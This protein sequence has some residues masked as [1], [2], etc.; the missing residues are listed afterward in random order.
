MD[1]L[2]FA[3][4]VLTIQDAMIIASIAT[5]LVFG[6]AAASKLM[7]V[8][9]FVAGLRSYGVPAPIAPLAAGCL[10]VCEGFIALAHL[11]AIGLPF[12]VPGTIVLLLIFFFAVANL[13]KRGEK[14]PCLCF[15]SSRGDFVDVSSLVRIALLLSVEVALY[16]YLAIDEAVIVVEAKSIEA[17]AIAASVVMLISWCLALP[18]FYR[19]WYVVRS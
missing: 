16:W 8:P 18:K 15:G 6:F 11:A 17:V 12:V 4:E 1:Q 2:S 9:G 5:G 13:L 3:S 19:A 10:F 7:D 14:R